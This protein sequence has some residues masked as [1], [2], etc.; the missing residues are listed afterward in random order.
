MMLLV[1]FEVETMRFST[2]KNMALHILKL[3]NN[4]EHLVNKKKVLFNVEKHSDTLCRQDAKL[5]CPRDI[6]RQTA[7]WE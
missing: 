7:S 1:Q 3:I 6:V 4:K 5:E 2:K